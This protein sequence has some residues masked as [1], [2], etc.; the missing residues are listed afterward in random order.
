MMSY[1]LVNMNVFWIL[2]LRGGLTLQKTQILHL[3]LMVC[4]DPP[5]PAL[6]PELEPLILV[7]FIQ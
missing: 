5:V 4:V 1:Q 6:Y 2:K 7:F 3:F